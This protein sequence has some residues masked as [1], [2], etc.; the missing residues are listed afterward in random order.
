MEFK[1]FDLNYVGKIVSLWNSSVAGKTIYKPFTEPY[2]VEKFVKNPYFDNEGFKL[3]FVENELVGYGHAIVNSNEAHPGFITLI[4]VDE[5]HQR[6]GYGRMILQE[7][8]N[9]LKSKG[10]NVIRLYFMSPINLEWYVPGTSCDHPGA[11]AV[12]YN[13]DY[14]FFLM[15]NGYITNGQQDA[16]YL[17]LTGYEVP[18]KV[19]VTEARAKENGYTITIYDPAVHHGFQELF[20]ALKNPGWYDAVKNNLS[21]EKPDPMLIVEKNGEI[22]GWTG[23]MYPQASK[24]GYFA[25]IGVHPE[26]QGHGLGKALFCELCYHSR[27]FGAN[28]MTYFTGADN[29]ARNIYLYAG[30]NI[31]QSFA[32]MR[33]DLK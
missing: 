20:E 8:E 24:R 5:K 23:P 3:L 29:L 9:Y 32:I 26:H 11:P 28:Y 33:K 1:N 14:Y 18:E 15:N 25:G 7:L 27:L 10:K 31:I 16:F 2:F 6:K 21:K 22:L 19:R 30:S 13:T 12:P 17:D 4:A